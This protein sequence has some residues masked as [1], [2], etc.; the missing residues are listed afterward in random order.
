MVA[1]L[2]SP[3][4]ATASGHCANIG[5][6][7]VIGSASGGGDRR[8][9]IAATALGGDG[10]GASPGPDIAAAGFGVTPVAADAGSMG[11][12]A[13][14]GPALTEFKV[15][16]APLASGAAPGLLALGADGTR[17]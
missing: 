5:G 9:V 8:A 7:G 10:A 17:K 16:E 4:A 2:Q 6:G 12:S 1:E 11:A 14:A 13:V 15:P 3:S